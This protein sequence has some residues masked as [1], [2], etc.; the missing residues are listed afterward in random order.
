[1]HKENIAVAFVDPVDRT[2]LRK[3]NSALSKLNSHNIIGKQ[4]HV[5]TPA[6]GM[7]YYVYC[8]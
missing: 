1:M 7:L 3:Q 8:V 4:Q 2:P 5:K 6:N